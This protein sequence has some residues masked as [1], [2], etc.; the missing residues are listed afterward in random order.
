MSA[1]GGYAD[2]GP[3]RP[4][5][6]EEVE[7]RP[8]I[9]HTAYH[10]ADG[11]ELFASELSVG[12]SKLAGEFAGDRDARRVFNV[13]VFDNGGDEFK[14]TALHF[15]LAGHRWTPCSG[16]LRSG[17]KVQPSINFF[18]KASGVARRSAKIW[19]VR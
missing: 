5:N 15:A 17:L 10:T 6:V 16:R 7:T 12:Q 4:G 2:L 19:P 1:F 14:M 11:L 8:R 3:K 9:S 18:Q 13:K